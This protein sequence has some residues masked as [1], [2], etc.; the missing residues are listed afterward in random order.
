MHLVIYFRLPLLATFF[1]YFLVK[2]DTPL[3][4]HII[5]FP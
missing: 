1:V 2:L 4:E 3:K 5:L